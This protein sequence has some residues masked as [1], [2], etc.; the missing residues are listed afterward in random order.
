MLWMQK[1]ISTIL[2]FNGKTEFGLMFPWIS[3]KKVQQWIGV[4]TMENTTKVTK[5]T[6]LPMCPLQIQ[7]HIKDSSNIESA[8]LIWKDELHI[9]VQS[10]EHRNKLVWTSLQK[11]LTE[12]LNWGNHWNNCHTWNDGKIYRKKYFK[13]CFQQWTSNKSASSI[14]FHPFIWNY[15]CPCPLLFCLHIVTV[16]ELMSLTCA[17]EY[18]NII[19]LGDHSLYACKAFTATPCSIFFKL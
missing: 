11:A 19:I 3:T 14:K 1:T 2:I 13:K 15:K 17:Y 8:S 16:F 5:M 7:T 18:Q 9:V 6:R 4:P 10:W 12:K